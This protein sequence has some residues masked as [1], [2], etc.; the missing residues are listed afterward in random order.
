MHPQLAGVIV[1]LML[2]GIRSHAGE[3]DRNCR[4]FPA[5]NSGRKSSRRDFLRGG[6]PTSK[7]T[8]SSEA[9]SSRSQALVNLRQYSHVEQYRK[10]AMACQFELLFNMH[11]YNHAGQT[12]MNSFRLIDDFEDQ[13]SIYREHSE[14]S[15]INRTAFESAVT[16]EPML[17]EMLHLAIEIY[18]Q[19][20]GA[21]DI[22][23]GSLSDLWGFSRRQGQV[24]TPAEIETALSRTGS[25]AIELDHST[26]QICFL[27]DGLKLNPGGIGKGYAVDRVTESIVTAGLENFVVH[28]GQSTVVARGHCWRADQVSNGWSIG[29]S[30]PKIPQRR[31]ATI[32][33]VNQA[34]GT[35]GT[36]RQAFFH[37]GKRYGHIIDPRTGNPANACLSSTAICDSAA[38]ADA[39]ATA[40]FVMG[41]EPVQQFCAQHPDVC[42][43][44]VL[45]GSDDSKVRIETFNSDD[46]D[47]LEFQ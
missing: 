8:D 39:L 38:R 3:S 26:K 27:R 41:V 46:S 31:L 21:F 32:R 18:E 43:L 9:D 1:T 20:A 33:L 12:A 14:I 34:L 24:P 4:L 30:H 37:N 5:M 40:F 16:V 36:Q 2:T 25:D 42:A 23:S 13:M 10:Q 47:I 19:T 15:H 44:L 6:F 7:P 29:L 45:P 22:T 17:F 11:E 28:A 35:S